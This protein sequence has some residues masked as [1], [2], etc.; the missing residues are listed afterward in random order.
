[1]ETIKTAIGLMSGTSLDGIDAALLQSDGRRQLKIL[2]HYQKPY[3]AALRKKLQQSLRDA[4]KIVNPQD[5]PGNL[6]ALEKELTLCHADAVHALLRRQNMNSA[7]IDLIGFHGQTVLHHPPSAKAAETKIIGALE[8]IG[9]LPSEQGFTVQLGDGALLAQKTGIATIADMRGNDMRYGGN[10]APLVPV[11]HRAL[12]AKLKNKRLFPLVFVNIGGIANCTYV[13]ETGNK[14]EP[15]LIACDCGPGNALLDQWTELHT[16]Q[17]FDKG[18]Q[19]AMNGKII[20][21]LVKAYADL[22]VFQEKHRSFDRND[23]PP[24]HIFLKNYPQMRVSFEDGAASLAFITAQYIMCSFMQFPSL[25]KTAIISGGGVKNGA[26]M[27]NLQ[28]MAEQKHIKIMKAENLGMDSEFM[29]AEAWAYLAIRSF[30]HLPLTYPATTGCR[31]AV[32]GGILYPAK[33][34]Q[35]QKTP[36]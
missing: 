18:G 11:Y 16:G 33:T 10:G 20:E 22:P 31:K 29:E 35:T 6:S 9:S 13:G 30:Y 24:L 7:D 15:E 32:S 4:Q 3:S 8:N 1:M 27:A 21:K 34:K 36:L 19:A 14:Q 25:P 12:A 5:R 28:H 26:V 2:G 23:F 17:F